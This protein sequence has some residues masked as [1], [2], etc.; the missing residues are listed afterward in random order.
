MRRLIPYKRFAIFIYLFLNLFLTN[1]AH[2]VPWDFEEAVPISAANYPQIPTGVSIFSFTVTFDPSAAVRRSFSGGESYLIHVPLPAGTNG[3]QAAFQSNFADPLSGTGFYS[4]TKPDFCPANVTNGSTPCGSGNY[5]YLDDGQGNRFE[6]V[7]GQASISIFDLRFEDGPLQSATTGYL[8]LYLQPGSTSRYDSSAIGF[9]ISI[10]DTALYEQWWCENI[11][12]EC[13]TE[14]TPTNYILNVS[15][16]GNG[17]VSVR[18]GSTELGQCAQNSGTCRYTQ[19]QGTN[20]SLVALPT[21]S[22]TTV[23]W[24]GNSGQC[25]ANNGTVQNVSLSS[26]TSCSVL[27]TEQAVENQ[28][29]LNILPSSNGTVTSTDNLIRCGSNG[30]ACSVSYTEGQQVSLQATANA[31]FRFTGWTGSCSGSN[32]TTSVTMNQAR[33]C[34]ANFAAQTVQNTAPVAQFAHWFDPETSIV[35]LDA[36]A[37]FDDDGDSITYQWHSSSK[38]TNFANTTQKTEIEY[39][40]NT[41]TTQTITLIVSDGRGGFDSTSRVIELPR[42]LDVD[43]TLNYTGG[44][45]LATTTLNPNV[46]FASGNL[47]VDLSAD[48][49]SIGNIPIASYQWSISDYDVLDANQPNL[50]I[51]LQNKDFLYAITLLVTDQNGRNSSISKLLQVAADSQAPIISNVV[52]QPTGIIEDQEGLLAATLDAGDTYDPDGGNL[53]YTWTSTG[54]CGQA[55]CVASDAQAYFVYD[56][57]GTYSVD[58]TVTDEEGQTTVLQNQQVEVKRPVIGALSVNPITYDA[59]RNVFVA[60][61]GEPLTIQVS[62]QSGVTQGTVRSYTWSYRLNDGAKTIIGETVSASTTFSP[63]Q[64]GQYVFLVDVEDNYNLLSISGS[65]QI[66]VDL[67]AVG[68]GRSLKS[69]AL[70]NVLTSA[71]ASFSGAVIDTQNNAVLG[72]QDIT[73]KASDPVKVQFTIDVAEED[74]GQAADIVSVIEFQ[75]ATVQQGQWYMQSQT[76][77]LPYIAWDAA[78][79]TASFTFNKAIGELKAQEQVVVAEGQFDGLVGDFKVFTG[80]RLQA[81]QN[82]AGELT[83]NETPLQF[84]VEE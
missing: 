34:E 23:T 26:N 72:N 11:S 50:T 30:S 39:S 73:V 46:Y 49:T 84:T 32:T 48:I 13:S 33:T 38:Q 55:A 45:Q 47:T 68:T 2:A 60:S 56:A 63:V 69:R 41:V 17:A 81:E 62:A 24:S 14:P 52:I 8:G 5:V 78:Q 79:N 70:D 51:S 9:S 77:T 19:P 12:R 42:P 20:L 21:N 31:G 1:Q 59:A 7:K 57:E 10:G 71:N 6:P 40:N 15:A 66:Q 35:Y 44:R 37:S 22:G 74:V 18:N 75:P 58:L 4:D 64:A 16:T 61:Y 83:F 65:G 29:N 76:E 3:V 27:F 36:S 82:E 25:S 53:T 67:P 80:Y 54:S 28:F 43:F